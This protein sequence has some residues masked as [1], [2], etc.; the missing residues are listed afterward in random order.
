MNF[1]HLLTHHPSYPSLNHHHVSIYAVDNNISEVR[2]LPDPN[3]HIFSNS[4]LISQFFS[5]LNAGL[6]NYDAQVS[7]FSICRITC[8]PLHKCLVNWECCNL[9]A[10]QLSWRWDKR[11]WMPGV[12]LQVVL[13]Q[14]A[15]YLLSPFSH[16]ASVGTPFKRNWTKRIRGISGDHKPKNGRFLLLPISHASTKPNP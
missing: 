4:W 10:T 13:L 1:S 16:P 5:P 15:A 2:V 6:D 9:T 7:L 8:F 11:S 3:S 12:G 14:H